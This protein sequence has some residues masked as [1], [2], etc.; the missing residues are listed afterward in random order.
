M[1]QFIDDII[2]IVESG[3]IHCAIDEINYEMLKT[4]EMKINSAK[5]KIYQRPKNKS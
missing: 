3:D 1:I 2:V 5:M 4:L